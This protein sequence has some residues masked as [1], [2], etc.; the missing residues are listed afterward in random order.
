MKV[1]CYF[2]CPRAAGKCNTYKQCKPRLRK[3][4]KRKGKKENRTEHE[5]GEIRRLDKKTAKRK[6]GPSDGAS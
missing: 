1:F 5:K 4:R 3:R 2:G 6:R